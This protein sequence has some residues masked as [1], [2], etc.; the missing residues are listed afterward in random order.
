MTARAYFLLDKTGSMGSEPHYSNTIAGYNAWLHGMQR[1][2]PHTKFTMVMFSSEST[3]TTHKDAHI[4]DVPNLNMET[5]RCDG[6]TPLF[7]AIC[8][9]IEAAEKSAGDDDRVVMIIQTDGQENCSPQPY[10]QSYVA[11]EIKRKQDKG[12][13]FVFLGADIDAYASG[14]AMGISRAATM[15]YSGNDGAATMSA[16]EAVSRGAAMFA[17]GAAE[18]VEFS[19]KQRADAG[20]KFVK[21]APTMSEP[22]AKPAADGT[23]KIDI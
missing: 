21:P 2:A 13:Q 11:A 4:S 15:S 16:Y 17:S 18:T 8:K 10:T 7:E 19:D 6:M 20:D 5:Y 23:V 12:W 14:K 1:D 22:E 3:V 9:L